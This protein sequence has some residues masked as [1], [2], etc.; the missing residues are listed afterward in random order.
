MFLLFA[1][2]VSL[3]VCSVFLGTFLTESGVFGKTKCDISTSTDTLCFESYNKI[4]GLSAASLIFLILSFMTNLVGIIDRTPKN[5][6]LKAGS[7]GL[8]L[9]YVLVQF[10]LL[11]VPKMSMSPT[12]GRSGRNRM[13]VGFTNKLQVR[14]RTP[15]MNYGIHENTFFNK[16][17]KLV[18][19][20]LK[21]FIAALIYNY[22]CNRCRSPL[23]L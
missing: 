2:F 21:E 12:K 7:Q 18:S 16:T 20:N 6:R 14:V 9:N 11:R 5:E 19:T 23:M 22:L 1:C 4:K 17:G 3:L 8:L 15:S 13:V 10:A